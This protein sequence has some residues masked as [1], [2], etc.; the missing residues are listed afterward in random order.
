MNRRPFRTVAG[1]RA[2]RASLNPAQWRLFY[3]SL[4]HERDLELLANTGPTAWATAELVAYYQTLPE[5]E[6]DNDE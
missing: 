2:F 1:F 5:E 3:H 4:R 6:E